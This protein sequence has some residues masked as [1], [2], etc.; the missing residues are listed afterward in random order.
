MSS[1]H[2]VVQTKAQ[3]LGKINTQMKKRLES[4]IKLKDDQ[5][6]NLTQQ[7]AEVKL[8]K[9][10]AE[11]QY[12]EADNKRKLA[13]DQMQKM[14]K[15]LETSSKEYEDQLANAN[16]EVEE[17]RGEVAVNFEWGFDRAKSQVEL[18][19]PGNDLS[20]LSAYKIIKDGKLVDEIQADQA[21]V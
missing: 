3:D 20:E 2:R 19:Y 12:K 15:V 4:D 18:L 21:E 9:A 7:L 5:I 1:K 16:A 14:Q 13:E 6:A 11:D 17:L 10:T 8:A